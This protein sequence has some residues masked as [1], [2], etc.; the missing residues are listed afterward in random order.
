MD[1]IP[2]QRLSERLALCRVDSV[3]STNLEAERRLRDGR[4]SGPTLIVAAEQRGGEGRRGAVWLSPRGGLWVTL[5][6]PLLE[7]PRE[8]NGL[9][10]RLGAACLKAV[11]HF[12]EGAAQLKW[13]ND[14]LIRDAKVCGCMARTATFHGSTWGI[15]GIGINVSNPMELASPGLGR[16]V[17]SLGEAMGSP[18]ALEGV[19]IVLADHLERLLLD[20]AGLADSLLELLNER[21]WGIGRSVELGQGTER[22]RGELLRLGPGGV[23]IV[24]DEAGRE[25]AV[26]P[27]ASEMSPQDGG[28]RSEE[29]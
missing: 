29:Q 11:D 6:W 20:D 26:H 27:G 7:P 21:L 22:V 8:L 3:D 25:V 9:G 18:P 13:P 14:I 16:A 15:A 19:L 23:P 17:T 5:I 1:R 2:D 24:R 4:V 12:V 10:L 28:S